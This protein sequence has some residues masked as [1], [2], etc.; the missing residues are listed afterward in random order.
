MDDISAGVTAGRYAIGP[1]SIESVA[2]LVLGA[3]ISAM[4]MVIEGH[5]TWRE[6]GSSTA[7]LLL[8]ALG[9]EA[10]EAQEIC[11]TELPRLP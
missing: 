3:T 6:A 9:I 7:E 11:T 2:S 1:S 5:Q 4:W 8:R 10:A